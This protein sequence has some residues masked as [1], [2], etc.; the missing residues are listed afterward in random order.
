MNNKKAAT[1][2]FQTQSIN[3]EL[4]AFHRF[5]ISEMIANCF[6]QIT[7]DDEWAREIDI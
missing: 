2:K 3:P 4:P 7:N 6:E 5:T 1:S